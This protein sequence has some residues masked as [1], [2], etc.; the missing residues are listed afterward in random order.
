VTAAAARWMDGWMA[1]L[2][3]AKRNAQTMSTNERIGR[4]VA[5]LP[6]FVP[7]RFLFYV[8]LLLVEG[9]NNNK[10]NEELNF[11]GAAK[12]NGKNEK[13]RDDGSKN[14]VLSRLSFSTHFY[15]RTIPIIRSANDFLAGRCH[16]AQS[17]RA[18][19]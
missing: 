3:R 10:M 17:Q 16:T 5:K 14:L 9:I 4:I 1:S 2:H 18:V 8:H 13:I 19:R 6:P 7:F 11:D 15:F 12:K